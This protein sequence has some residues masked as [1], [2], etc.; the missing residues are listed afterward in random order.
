MPAPI[1]QGTRLSFTFSGTNDGTLLS[2]QTGEV[3]VINLRWYGTNTISALTV[4]GVN[5]TLVGSPQTG[6]PGDGRSQWAWVHWTGSS[7]NQT[8]SITLSGSNSG[9]VEA[10]RVSGA[11]T[12]TP[13][14]SVN[15]ASGSGTTPSVTLNACPAE[16]LGLAIGLSA[17]SGWSSPTSGW[18]LLTITDSV[19]FDSGAQNADLG[20]SGDKTISATVSSGTWQINAIAITPAGGASSLEQEGFRFGADDGSESAHTWLAAQDANATVAAGGSALVNI[21][22]NVTGSP[23]SRRFTLQHRKVGDALWIDTP[24]Q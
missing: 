12:A 2:V 18:S 21:L 14:G 6:G 17:S 23:G 13:V 16:C 7:G 5:A 19:F 1:H 15:G 10:W 4:G 22:V 9:G 11:D 20:A 8:V 24:I 3:V